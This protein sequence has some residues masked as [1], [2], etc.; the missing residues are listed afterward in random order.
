MQS[1]VQDH[2]NNNPLDIAFTVSSMI[3]YQAYVA[4][5]DQNKSVLINGLSTSNKTA[6]SMNRCNQKGNPA[7]K[8]RIEYK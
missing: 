7:L 5:H 6:M 4:S 2:K 1:L 8:T 3:Y